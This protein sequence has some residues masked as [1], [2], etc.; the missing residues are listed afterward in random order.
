M[1]VPA[2]LTSSHVLPSELHTL[3]AKPFSTLLVLL[4]SYPMLRQQSQIIP[5]NPVIICTSCSAPCRYYDVFA[6]YCLIIVKPEDLSYLPAKCVSYDTVANLLAYA[7][8]ESVMLQSVIFDKHNK[9]TVCLFA[10]GVVNLAIFS[11]FLDRRKSLHRPI[12][13]YA[14]ILAGTTYS[15]FRAY[16][17]SIL[18]LRAGREIS[19]NIWSKNNEPRIV[20]AQNLRIISIKP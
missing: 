14:C 1:P 15:L 17:L 9:N 3:S 10:C 5:V 8:S 11:V 16:Y 13:C 6:L 7:Y 18:P 19:R 12:F 4:H 2:C 20:A